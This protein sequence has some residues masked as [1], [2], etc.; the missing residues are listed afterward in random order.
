MKKID[1]TKRRVV[2][3]WITVSDFSLLPTTHGEYFTRKKPQH[4]LGKVI[5]VEISLPKKVPSKPK[6]K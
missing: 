1:T 3:A 4:Y 5:E 2:K 6:K